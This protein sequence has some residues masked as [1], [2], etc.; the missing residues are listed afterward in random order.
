MP[1]KNPFLNRIKSGLV[2]FDGGLGT[3]I[4]A[5]GLERGAC[6]DAWNLSHPQDIKAIHQAYYEAGSDVVTTNS[7]GANIFLLEKYGL[8]EKVRELNL[9]A[10]RL[11]REVCP[12]GRFVAGSMGPTGEFLQPVGTRTCEEIRDA[13]RAQVTALR[14]GGVD[15]ICIETMSDLEEIRAAVE[16]ARSEADL[17]VC[18]TM[19]FDLGKRGFRTMMGA[20]PEQAAQVLGDA[21]ADVIGS[22]CGSITILDMAALARE[23]RSVSTLPI[24]AQANAGMPRLVEGRTV[25]PQSPEDFAAGAIPLLEAGAGLIGGCCGTTPEHIR[26]VVEKVC[27]KKSDCVSIN[28]HGFRVHPA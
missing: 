8:G 18:A 25:H 22:N 10:A 3:Q 19:T 12:P 11:A 27:G 20:S 26:A 4:Q 21:G 16:A 1:L 28:E 23:F 24:L 2:I 6:P 5:R 9:A 7:F 15:I 17:P 14:D 13:Y